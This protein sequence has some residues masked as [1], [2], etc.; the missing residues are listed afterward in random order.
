MKRIIAFLLAAVMLFSISACSNQENTPKEPQT[1]A[2]TSLTMG[3]TT[4]PEGLDPQRTAAASTFSVTNNI[5]DTLVSVTSDWE[6][7]PRLAKEWNV[8]ENGMEIT[9]TL[10]DD[11]YFHNGRQMTAKDV[12]YSFNRLKDAESPKAKDYDNIVKIETF[13]DYNIKFTTE[14]LDVELLKRFAY[15]WTAIVP[16][17]AADNLKTA[18]VGTGAFKLK[19]WNPQQNLTLERNDNYFG[20][21]AKLETVKLV[22]IPDATSMMASFQVGDLDIIPLTG[23]QV[24]M[25]EN[26]E[27]YQVISE[28]MNAVQILSINTDNEILKN[29]KVRQAMAMAINKDEVIEASMF[30]YGDKIGSHLPPTSPDYYDTNN[31]IE[32]NPEKAK[33]LLKEAGYEN[34]FDINMTLPKN[35]QLHVDAGQVIADQLGKIGI[36]VKIE[37]V[38]WGTWLSDVY[39]AKKFDTTVVGHTGRLDSYAF[40]ARYKSD[41]NDYISL[42]T[43]E[44]D[45]LLADALKELD[46]SKRKEIYKQ[47]QVILAEKLPAIY[48]QTPRTMLALQKDVQGMEIFPIDVYDFSTVSFAE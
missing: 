3:Y 36:N 1:A 18:P 22:L 27:A 11:V 19:E 20:E 17:E 25:V 8:S 33:E 28:P 30:G 4:E 13:D 35:Y 5:Y 46:E 7:V 47:I 10:R 21:K 37:I 23:D 39:T 6:I 24:T 45:Q 44:V 41:S 43:G 26:N 31:M 16:E 9:F 42:K 38:E 2:K 40:L 12:E 29:E 14:T 15:P 34:G 32:Y 48:L